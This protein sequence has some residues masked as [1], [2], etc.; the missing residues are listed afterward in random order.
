MMRRPDISE[1]HAHAH[2]SKEGGGGVRGV[3]TGPLKFKGESIYTN[4]INYF[5]KIK[6]QKKG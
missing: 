5:F 4:L 6:I 2:R 3:Q 1:V